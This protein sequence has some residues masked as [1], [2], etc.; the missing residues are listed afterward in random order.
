MT[1]DDI[2]REKGHGVIRSL[3]SALMP[4]VMRLLVTEDIGSVVATDEEGSV[5]G[6]LT[7]RD[8]LRL[9]AQ[10]PLR[11]TS[12]T[13]GEVMS[14]PVLVAPPT[15]PLPNVMETMTDR[16]IRHLPVV[17]QGSLCGIVSIGDVVNAYREDVEAE[18]RLL[19]DYLKLFMNGPSPK[20][21]PS[22]TRW[23]SKTDSS[24][25]PGGKPLALELRETLSEKGKEVVTVSPETSLLGVMETLVDHQIG[26]VLVTADGVVKGILTERDTLRACAQDPSTLDSRKA[27]DAMTRDLIVGVPSDDVS[28]AMDVMVRN[29]I[30]H[31]PVFHEGLLEGM[32]SI[33]DVTVGLLETAQAEYRRLRDSIQGEIW[34]SS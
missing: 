14:R 1:I 8:I 33:G 18:T 30:R 7:E 27:G 23:R 4:E 2:L 16:R 20:A 24:L 19:R 34:E 22:L 32:V 10:D 6:I 15:E 31:L 26:S 21:R 17:D 3:P 29:R 5:R 13:L 12:L 9:G 25:G 28:W 11:L